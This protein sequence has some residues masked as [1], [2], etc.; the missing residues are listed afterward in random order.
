MKKRGLPCNEDLVGSIASQLLGL[1][2][3]DNR[4]DVYNAE[5]SAPSTWFCETMACL[6][7]ARYSGG[8]SIVKVAA[9]DC[10]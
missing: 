1:E 9:Y 5:R 2:I 8:V 4:E 3:L 10:M 7:C 6:G